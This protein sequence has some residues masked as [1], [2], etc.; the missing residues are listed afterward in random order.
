MSHMRSVL[1]LDSLGASS[2]LAYFLAFYVI[3]LP[4][5]IYILYMLMYLQV[6]KER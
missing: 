2:Q 5:Q 6:E 4:T 3:R 1:D